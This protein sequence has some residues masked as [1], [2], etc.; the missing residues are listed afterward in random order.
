[1]VTRVTSFAGRLRWHLQALGFNPLIRTT[2]RLEAFAVLA[3]LLTAL[4]AIPIAS[5]AGDVVYASAAHTAELQAHDRHP[6]QATVV[7][8]GG[9]LPADVEGSASGGPAS[10]KAQWH[11]GTRLRTEQIT[12]PTM[13]KV[14][15]SLTVWLDNAGKVVSAPL[16]A[17][18]AE[19]SA[20]VASGTVWI[21]IVAFG[22]LAVFLVRR[23][24]DRVRD[25]AWDSALHLL[26]HNDD[27]WA[28]RHA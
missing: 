25:R 9:R 8:G 24:L 15:D 21:A 2:D 4:I 20:A 7:E 19:V 18:D 23:V 28:N 14:G 13:A 27:G 6:V 10:V 22:A 16:T 12:G 1:M 5:H 11:E 17:D 26:A 3:A